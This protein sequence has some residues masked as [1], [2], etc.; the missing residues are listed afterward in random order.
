MSNDDRQL[1]RADRAWRRAIAR[2]LRSGLQTVVVAIAVSWSVPA[3][4]QT[5]TLCNVSM[6]WDEPESTTPAVASYV[7]QWGTT[8]R[9][10]RSST[11]TDATARS[12]VLSLPNG[13]TQYVAA[14][15]VAASGVRSSF[16]NEVRVVVSCNATGKRPPQSVGG[17]V[18]FVVIRGQ[19]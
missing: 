19:R 8:P 17:L 5:P 11:T 7:L 9:L 1:V 18:W 16:S 12:V 15:A 6:A 14:Q 2:C 13:S 3:I 4:A 10:Y